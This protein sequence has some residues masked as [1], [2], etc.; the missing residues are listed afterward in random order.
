[1]M[2]GNFKLR[3]YPKTVLTPLKWDVYI[4]PIAT[5]QRTFQIGSFV[6]APDFV[7]NPSSALAFKQPFGCFARNLPSLSDFVHRENA[8][9][10]LT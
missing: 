5:G 3:H 9:L 2:R 6:S 7:G 1:M 10:I 4:T 8:N